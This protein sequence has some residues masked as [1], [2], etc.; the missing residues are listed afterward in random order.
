MNL[1]HTLVDF[2]KNPL[3]VFAVHEMAALVDGSMATKLTVQFNLFGG[4][5]LALG[6]PEFKTNHC[7]FAKA[8][9]YFEE[10][11]WSEDHW[12]LCPYRTGLREQ[13]RGDGDDSAVRPQDP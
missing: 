2:E 9:G 13:F 11:G 12:L 8:L 7:R 1:N 6:T 4:T 5:L 3:N 10:S